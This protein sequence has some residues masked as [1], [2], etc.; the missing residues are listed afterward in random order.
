MQASGRRLGGPPREADL[1]SG[2]SESPPGQIQRA[3]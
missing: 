1:L 3:G 2:S